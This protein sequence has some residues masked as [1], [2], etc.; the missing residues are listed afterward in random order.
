MELLKRKYFWNMLR[1]SR[2]RALNQ[3]LIKQP[4]VVRIN[5]NLKLLLSTDFV[6]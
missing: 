4:T 5:F 1:I 6:C 2:R 3:W